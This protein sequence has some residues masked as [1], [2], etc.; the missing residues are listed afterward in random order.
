MR[1]EKL[2]EE[3]ARARE[4]WSG[5][6]RWLKTVAGVV[7]GL[8]L[9]AGTVHGQDDNTVIADWTVDSV[10]TMAQAFGAAGA[11][12]ST[13]EH[14]TVSASGG[15]LRVEE[16]DDDYSGGKYVSSAGTKVT[17]IPVAMLQE[18]DKPEPSADKDSFT[19]L[20]LKAVGNLKLF[21]E[22][23]ANGNSTDAE[24]LGLPFDSPATANTVYAA[25]NAL[26]AQAAA[27]KAD[28][29]KGY[30]ASGNAK[31]AKGDWAGAIDDATL[32][33]ALMPDYAE[34][35]N[36]RGLAKRQQQDLNGAIVDYSQAIALKPDFATAYSNRGWAKYVDAD[37]AGALEDLD[38]AVELNPKGALALYDRGNVHYDQQAWADALKDY[39]LA[40]E[41]NPSL[42]RARNRLWLVMA[43]MG[44][45][46]VA[47][48]QVKEY[49]AG[50]KTGKPD[51]WTVK[52]GDYLTGQLSE[53]DLIAAAASPNGAVNAAQKSEAYFYIGAK[54][55]IEGN[56]TAAVRN[57]RLSVVAAWLQSD[58][59]YISSME[60]MR[61][62]DHPTAEAPPPPTD[63][64]AAD[65]PWVA[66]DILAPLR[67]QT[68]IAQAYNFDPVPH[69][70]GRGIT[71]AVISQGMFKALKDSLGDRVS[72]E[73]VLASDP[74]P[75]FKDDGSGEGGI[76]V[77]GLVAALAPEAKIISIK[78]L[79]AD[80]QASFAD[81]AKAI[82]RA[83]E[84][85]AS[86]LLLPIGSDEDNGA[87]TS[88]VQ[89]SLSKGVLVVAS[90]GNA[91][92]YGAG[93]PARMYGVAAVG[94]V[95]ENDKVAS[96]SNYGGGI[97]Y[98]PGDEVVSVSY[99]SNRKAFSGTTYAVGVA[100]GIYAVVW[101]QNPRLTAA[102]VIGLVRN[103][104]A[105]VADP[106]GSLAPR[107]DGQ[108]ALAAVLKAG[109]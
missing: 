99:G 42:D 47:T 23:A 76:E 96:Y 60:A 53:A 58:V 41:A 79:D 37:T 5:V 92:K 89:A 26:V 54:D 6:K 34:A 67:P 28:S 49:L 90:A 109:K 30:F 22:V 62:L 74:D 19:W 3:P 43:K 88:A 12:D 94:A 32:A 2:C 101:S 11:N 87:V 8:V 13:R 57:F 4:R 108:A 84:L 82:A 106:S 71:V 52:I 18:V 80:G 61:A 27:G 100:G 45:A 10:D 33:I 46:D 105:M 77:E 7:G 50:R 14:R 1:R 17:T 81:I 16:S 78:A 9:M 98:A 93:F 103:H 104:A 102:A 97:I 20:E 35:Y 51:D 72:A 86:I 40:L 48:V 21:H 31:R 70:A 73:S 69:T 25:V 75:Y 63:L 83:T 68:A 56:Q 24:S 95:D 65:G 64:T 36:L 59:S 91:G 15:V 44:Q 39:T 85:K 55:L 29:A 107:M 66:D 38:K